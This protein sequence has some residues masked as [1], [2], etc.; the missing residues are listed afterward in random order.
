MKRKSF[1]LVC[2]TLTVL[3][4]K[5]LVPIFYFF[6]QK[7]TIIAQVNLCYK[8]VFICF[9]IANKFSDRNGH[10]DGKQYRRQL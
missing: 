7:Q 8:F 2:A 5:Q 6:L 4:L 9:G 10:F 3:M 1:E